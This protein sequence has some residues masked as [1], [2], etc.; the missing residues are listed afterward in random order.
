M[1]RRAARL[2]VLMG[3]RN[4]DELLECGGIEG[5]IFEQVLRDQFELITMG[6]EN[7]FGFIVSASEDFFDLGIDESGG[8]FAAI[9]LK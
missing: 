6:G 4:A 1:V 5:F 3:R 9:A 8:L 7:R 2:L